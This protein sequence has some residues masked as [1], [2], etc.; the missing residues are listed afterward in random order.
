MWVIGSAFSAEPEVVSLEKA[1]PELVLI[2][3]KRSASPRVIGW[4]TVSY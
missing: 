2:K 4:L 1:I 3:G